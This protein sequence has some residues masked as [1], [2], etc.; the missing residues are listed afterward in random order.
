MIDC[1]GLSTTWVQHSEACGYALLMF[2]NEIATYD[3]QV[4]YG[5]LSSFPVP[6]KCCGVASTTY[7]TPL[8]KKQDIVL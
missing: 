8:C 4:E 7:V 2:S 5:L 6:S 1:L 3:K